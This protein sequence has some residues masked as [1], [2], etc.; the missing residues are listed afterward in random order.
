MASRGTDLLDQES[1]LARPWVG[2]SAHDRAVRSSSLRILRSLLF[3]GLA[4][5]KG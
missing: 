2:G 5:S 3:D 1:R 4:A